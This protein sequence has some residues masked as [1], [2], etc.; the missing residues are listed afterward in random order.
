[1]DPREKVLVAMSLFDAWRRNLT[2]KTL[3]HSHPHN[4]TYLIQKLMGFG[5]YESLTTDNGD[6]NFLL[7]C[8]G[9]ISPYEDSRLRKPDPWRNDDLA[10]Q[11]QELRFA[12]SWKMTK[13]SN[14]WKIRV[15]SEI[16]VAVVV[17]VA[18]GSL[19]NQHFPTFW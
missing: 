10:R 12:G 8:N 3:I 9:L 19:D 15:D 7:V 13:V 17:K 4:D 6:W 11:Y 2:W 1:M 16:G 14:Y 5:C 18:V